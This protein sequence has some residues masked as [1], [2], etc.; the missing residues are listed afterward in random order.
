MLGFI[1]KHFFTGLAFLSILASANS[2]S[3]ISVNNQECKVRPRIVNING[4]NP[5][6]FPFSIKASK[7]NGSCN[8][9][10]NPY[11]KLCIPDAVKTLNVKMFNL[12]SRTNETRYIEWH[13][14]CKCKYRL[15]GSVCN[16]KQ[17]WND[18]NCRCE[19]KELIDKG[20]S[21]KGFICNP[22]NCECKCY[23]SCDIGEYLDYENCKCRK[24]LVDKLPE[25]CI[26]NVEEI[27]IA[28]ITLTEDENKCKCSSCTLHIALFST[29]RF[30]N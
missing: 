23:K 28:K 20:V 10:N 7:R 18:D 14:T 13:E 11:T 19:C 2:L 25:E 26:E 6:F 12:M 1:K 22:S 30:Y 17:C 27:K 8:N 16:N 24:K 3:Y 15:D 29:N 21:D 5:V 9:I 4:D